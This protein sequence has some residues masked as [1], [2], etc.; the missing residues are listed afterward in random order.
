MEKKR[1]GIGGWLNTEKA[2]NYLAYGQVYKGIVKMSL[3]HF[4]KKPEDLLK[5]A[6]EYDDSEISLLPYHDLGM[7]P[8]AFN[9]RHYIEVK[10]KGLILLKKPDLTLNTHNIDELVTQLIEIS[11]TKR[12]S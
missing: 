9:F 8:I 1:F 5:E 3:K 11:K 12:I 7:L 2:Q 6:E 10:L 4:K